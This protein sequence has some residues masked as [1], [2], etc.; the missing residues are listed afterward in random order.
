MLLK[1][2]HKQRQMQITQPIMREYFWKNIGIRPSEPMA[3]RTMG[4]APSPVTAFPTDA[5]LEATKTNHFKNE[6][7]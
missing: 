1:S 2:P 3:R 7:S 6:A 4:P 5:Q